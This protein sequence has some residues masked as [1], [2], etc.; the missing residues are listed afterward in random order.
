M[1]RMQVELREAQL[2]DALFLV[3]LWS[4]SLRRADTQ[5]QVADLETIIKG[6]AESPER[7]LLIAE[8]D[9]QPAGAVYL[10]VTTQSPLNLE[11]TLQMF[12]LTVSPAYRRKGVGHGLLDGAVSFAERAGV[13]FVAT[14]AASAS[15]DGNRF[16]ARLGFGPQAVWRVASV[17]ALRA[18][19]TPQLPVSARRPANRTSLVLAAR[20]SMR[21]AR[22]GA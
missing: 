9:G 11:P 14:A 7:A 22:A 10:R 8:Y 2:D 13:P 15:R 20:R 1:S 5:E 21:R 16:L 3:E 17:H 12:S 6:A 19:V 18:K 4:D